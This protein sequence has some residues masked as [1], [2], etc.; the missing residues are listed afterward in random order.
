[1]GDL[2]ALIGDLFFF[3]LARKPPACSTGLS[4][5]ETVACQDLHQAL[6]CKWPTQQREVGS[7]AVD[8]RVEDRRRRIPSELRVAGV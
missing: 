6:G 4:P 1:M 5:G 2:D 8:F 3:A 7:S